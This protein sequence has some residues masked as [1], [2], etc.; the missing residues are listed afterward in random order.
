[1]RVRAQRTP[2]R[3]AASLG[4]SRD[5]RRAISFG[6]DRSHH[7]DG[8]AYA[9]LAVDHLAA[10]FGLHAGAEAYV[11]RSLDFADA[12]GVMHGCLYSFV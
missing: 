11:A 10:F 6:N 7:L 1:M 4:Y 3:V 2:I 8:A 12:V 5:N 9:A